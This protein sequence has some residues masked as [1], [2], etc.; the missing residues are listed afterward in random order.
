[1]YTQDKKIKCHLTIQIKKDYIHVIKLLFV[2]HLHQ[3]LTFSPNFNL[4]WQKCRAKVGQKLQ[5]GLIRVC[6]TVI[7]LF[8]QSRTSC[9]NHQQLN[10]VVCK[11][12]ILL[13]HINQVNIFAG[14]M[15]GAFAQQKLLIFL[16]QKMEYFQG[17]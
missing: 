10:K 11:G 4:L 16:Q 14:K 8:Q 12:L 9:S 2:K 5:S 17:Q 15:S 3:Q 1:M 13:A 6:I 7:G